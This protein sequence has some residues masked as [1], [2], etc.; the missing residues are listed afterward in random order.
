MC[1]GRPSS[2]TN[3]PHPLVPYRQVH[4]GQTTHI[5]TTYVHHIAYHTHA[6]IFACLCMPPLP[7]ALPLPLSLCPFFLPPSSLSS[8]LSSRIGPAPHSLFYLS[9][10][11]SSLTRLR[12]SAPPRPRAQLRV[13]QAIAGLC[14]V[15]E[16]RAGWSPRAVGRRTT[17][18][19]AGT[20]GR[21]GR[22]AGCALRG[23]Q[24][25]APGRGGAALPGRA[26]AGLAARGGRSS[27][28][29]PPCSDPE[30]S[31]VKL[32]CLTTV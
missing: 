5:S 3:F 10:S 4:V 30:A 9:P 12:N 32:T 11:S 23:G 16:R 1:W 2:A 15:Q 14:A 24:R 13:P 26:T 7:L 29:G 25:R 17:R 20:R 22:E 8:F 19:G 31:R 18:H 28:T 6:F 27:R 21:T